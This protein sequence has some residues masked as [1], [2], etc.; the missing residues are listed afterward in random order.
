MKIQKETVIKENVL[1]KSVSKCE[2]AIKTLIICAK[3]YCIL[4]KKVL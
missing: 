1:Y 2:L 3:L 4:N